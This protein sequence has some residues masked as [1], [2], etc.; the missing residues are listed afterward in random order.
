MKVG[1]I[2]SME[3]VSDSTVNV[4]MLIEKKVQRF[5]KK[6]AIASIRREGLMDNKVINL[7]AVNSGN[8]M[9]EEGAV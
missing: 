1:T 8:P 6:D 9:V 4:D 5:M 3:I 2:N 7:L